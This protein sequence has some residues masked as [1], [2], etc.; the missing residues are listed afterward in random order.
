MISFGFLLAAEAASAPELK[1]VV[2]TPIIHKKYFLGEREL[3]GYNPEFYPNVVTFGPDNEPYIRTQGKKPMIQTLDKNGK[4]IKLDFTSAIKKR[5]PH[6]NGKIASGEFDDERI[7]FD[8][9]GNAYMLA[10]TGRSNLHRVLLMFSNDRCRSWQIFPLSDTIFYRLER[11]GAK[12]LKHPPVIM[13]GDRKRQSLEIIVPRLDE[14]NKLSLPDPVTVSDN[15][16]YAAIHSGGECV[17][18]A[19]DKV[20]IVWPAVK[21]TVKAD[22]STPQYIAVYD[23]KTGKVSKPVLLGANGLEKQPDP[24]NVPSVAIDSKGYIHVILGAHHHPFK[25]TRSLKPLDINGGWTK[26]VY[27]GK[28]GNRKEGRY[29]YAAFYC[30]KKD[31]LHLISRWAGDRYIF[32]LVYMRK[33]PGLPWEE[34]K[35]LVEPFKNNYVCWYHK[36]TADRKDRLFLRY[37]TFVNHIDRETLEAYDKK[38]PKEKI[39]SK[40]RGDW[41]GKPG[42][43]IAKFRVKAH[44]P[45]ILISD[46]NGLS[47][48]I[49]VSKDFQL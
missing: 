32:R 30:D 36:L 4:W 6:W 15:S 10:A 45:V 38:W 7:I 48:R 43:Q 27:I 49:A 16:L 40:Q 5:F 1:G 34:Q 26:P 13:H 21:K 23:R 41:R 35:Y 11:R 12:S 46:D 47:W 44:D 20:F 39:K 2:K 25:Y 8:D 14:N 28:C 9:K 37:K 42:Q 31:N 3:F 18:S 29:T 22:G 17:E 33:K 24:H 19:A